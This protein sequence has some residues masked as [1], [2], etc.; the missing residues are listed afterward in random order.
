MKETTS[1][2]N[3]GK[4]RQ[5]RNLMK[6]HGIFMIINDI[7]DKMNEINNIIKVFF[8]VTIS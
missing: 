6:I 5:L 2:P 3:R 7:T 8:I 1:R 4:K